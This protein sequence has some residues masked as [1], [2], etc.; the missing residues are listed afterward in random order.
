MKNFEITICIPSYNGADKILNI[1]R[2]LEQ[3]TF[4]DFEVIIHLDGS[5]DETERLLDNYSKNTKLKSFQFSK[6]ENKGR[7]RSRNVL[8]N[9]AKGELLL[10]F[11][12]DMRP[13][14]DVVEK[15]M[16]FH[17]ERKDFILVGS[18]IDDPIASKNDIQKYKVYLSKKWMLSP[19]HNSDFPLLT[20]AHFSISQKLF[21]FLGGFDER[22]TDS[23]DLDL[24]V[25]AH[26]KKISIYLDPSI[27]AWHDDF[28]SFKSYIERQR[29]YSKSYNYLVKINPLIKQYSSKEYVPKKGLRL[30]ILHIMS[31]DFILEKIINESV[32]LKIL[33][34]YVRYSLYGLSILA[35]SKQ[36][37]NKNISNLQYIKS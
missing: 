13:E 9:K 28:I 30:F 35:L 18:Q 27:I 20:A 2:A 29:E 23:E 16:L 4:Q 11:D 8:A 5:I 10:F 26:D 19:K 1:L 15:H 36:F 12:D 14:K 32:F 31:S 33:P 25:R 37:P 6:S 21:S 22:L 17:K 34:K 7:A 3:Q 24:S